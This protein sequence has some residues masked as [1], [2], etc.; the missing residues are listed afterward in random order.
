MRL[1]KIL[2]S[3]LITLLAL[4]GTI[5]AANAFGYRYDR[6]Y[7]VDPYAYHY[8]SPRYYPHYNSRYWRHPEDIRIRRKKLYY[9]P[10][11]EAWGYPS[12]RTYSNPRTYR[13]YHYRYRW[14]R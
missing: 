7:R 8:K 4:M 13:F 1:R 2:A 5:T 3:A 12:H 14:R 9:P 11:Y 10:Y 6:G